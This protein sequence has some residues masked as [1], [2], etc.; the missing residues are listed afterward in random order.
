M[1]YLLVKELSG[2]KVLKCGAVF[3]HYNKWSKK[4]E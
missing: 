4:G 3:H 1:A 2:G